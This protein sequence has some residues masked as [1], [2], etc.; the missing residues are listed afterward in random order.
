MMYT[1]TLL[2][3]NQ[4]FKFSHTVFRVTILVHGNSA[5]PGFLLREPESSG[6]I[7][8]RDKNER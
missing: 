2:A 1:T 8:Q 4:T 3:I 6:N 5:D 7:S